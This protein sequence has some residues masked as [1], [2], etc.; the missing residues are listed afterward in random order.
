MKF[1]Q[2]HRK[3]G[4]KVSVST[5]ASKPKIRY[6]R[7]A[8]L[9]LLVSPIAFWYFASPVVSVHFSH[10]GK[11]EFRYIWNVQHQIYK[12]DM[13]VGGGASVKFGHIFPDAGFFMRFDWWTDTGTQRCVNVTPKWGRTI[14]I[15]LDATGGIDTA[16]T[17]PDVISRLKQCAGESDPFR[18]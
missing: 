8:F 12:G 1:L 16:K 2:Y 15:Y 6:G 17:A 9:L 4:G 3:H 10:D 18:S 11:E 14:D 7:W 13:P 5:N